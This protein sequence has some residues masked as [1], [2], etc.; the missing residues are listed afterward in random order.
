[1]TSTQIICVLLGLIATIL[2]DILCGTLGHTLAWLFAT[3]L[4]SV[5]LSIYYRE[6]SERMERRL[7]D[8]HRK[9]GQK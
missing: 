1:M 6:Q 9:Y 5:S 4:L 3:S 7:R 8:Y 2:L